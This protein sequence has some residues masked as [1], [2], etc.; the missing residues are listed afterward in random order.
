[1][2]K[3]D[4]NIMRGIIVL[5]YTL[6]VS[7]LIF[8][9]SSAFTYLNTGADRS[10]LLHTEVRKLDQYLPKTIWKSDGNEGRYV[11]PQTLGEVENDYL[12]AWYVRHVAYKSNKTVGIDDYY[13]DN[14]RKNLFSFIEQNTKNNISIEST[15][16]E[17]HPDILFFSEDGQLIVLKDENVVEYKKIY[18]NKKLIS[19]I[20]EVSSYKMI[21]LLEDGFWRIRHLVKENTNTYN[22]PKNDASLKY[23]NIKGINYYPQATPWDMFGKKFDIEIIKKD[24]K[25]IKDAGLNT[26]RIFVQY[27]DFGK[28]KV[29]YEKLDKLKQVLDNAEKAGIDV[30]VTLF[31]FYGNYSTLD[32]TLNHRHAERIVSMFKD[33]KAIMAWDVKN[34][35]NLDFKSRGKENVIAWLKSMITLIKSI[36]TKHPIT[37]GWSD[38]DSAPILQDKID[39]ISFHYYKE[40]N[41]FENEFLSLKEKIKNKPIVLGE[42]GVSSYGGFWRPFAGSEKKQA[43][44][45]KKMQE[46]LKKHKIPFISWTLY[47]FNKIPASVV[48][49]RPWRVYPQKKFGF[50]N[51]DGQKKPSFAHIS[52]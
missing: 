10:K 38:A 37:I 3:I 41:N 48:G 29:K 39:F 30:I 33:H 40:L 44:Y 2:V 12:D 21:L 9:I 34:E 35:P 42:F 46:V 27:D 7:V 15:T 18:H 51:K 47:D 4:K 22:E 52:E 31:D 26:I 45:Y 43:L 32:W 16:V 25:I 11:D 24:F 17:H 8:L 14:A 20:T 49:K 19:E 50:I 13:T 23:A 36:D 5:S 1:M 6:S 28:A